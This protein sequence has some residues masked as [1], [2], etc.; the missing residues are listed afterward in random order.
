MSLALV[1][2]NWETYLSTYQRSFF[3]RSLQ[4]DFV[5]KD[6]LPHI[7]SEHTKVLMLNFSERAGILSLALVNKNWETFLS[8]SQEG[9]GQVYDGMYKFLHTGTWQISGAIKP[10]RGECSTGYGFTIDRE[11]NHPQSIELIII[12]WLLWNNAQ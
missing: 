12:L 7:H 5:L 10:K 2:E 1:N 9:L 6:K 4:R 8:T 3:I 11:E